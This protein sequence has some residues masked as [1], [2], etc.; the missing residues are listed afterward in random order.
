MTLS[1]IAALFGTMVVLAM[2]PGPS[3]FAVVEI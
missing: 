2:I 3:V 1:N